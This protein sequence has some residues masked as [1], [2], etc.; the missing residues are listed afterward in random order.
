MIYA[1]VL[2]M[3][4]PFRKVGMAHLVCGL[5]DKSKENVLKL[6]D[7]LSDTDLHTVFKRAAGKGVGIELNA[8]DMKFKD[9]E[10]SI[11]LRPFEIAKK[12]GCKFYLGSDAHHPKELT[13]AESA[14]ERAVNL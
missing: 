9:E 11:I 5:M 2:D 7:S 3:D 13:E 1:A 6:I 4:L 10:K 12:D 14:F 8:D